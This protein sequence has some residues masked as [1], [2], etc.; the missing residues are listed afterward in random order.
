MHEAGTGSGGAARQFY[1]RHRTTV[2]SVVLSAVGIATGTATAHA[3]LQDSTVLGPATMGCGVVLA[4][5]CCAVQTRHAALAV[6]TAVAPLPG[7]ILAAP[8]SDGPAFGFVPFLAYAFGFAVAAMH[9]EAAV[10]RELDGAEREHPWLPAVTAVGL[11][12]VW[13]MIW[14][15]RTRSADAAVQAIVDVTGTTLSAI[16]LV[17]MGAVL[18]PFDENFVVRIN[19]AHERRRRLCE[20]LAPATVPRWAFSLTG[21]AFVFLALGWF[22]AEPLFGTVGTAASLRLV[23][24]V[25]LLAAAAA[26]IAGGWREA[27]AV[28][29]VAGTAALLTLW[30]MALAWRGIF[31]YPG[32]LEVAT[33][34]VF[35]A[36]C[37]CRQAWAF[38]RF[39]DKPA[40]ARKRALEET[41]SGLMFAS[42]GAIAS[43]VPGLIFLHRDYAIYAGAMLGAAAGGIFFAPAAAA[44]VEVLFPRRRSAEE[45]YGKR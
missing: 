8:V 30:G 14:F 11:M 34:S 37:C 23:L 31:H 33:F 42:A 29:L 40:L 43:M 36:L 38:R 7:L 25:S 12:A 19:R 26:R 18:L 16:V 1:L 4:A 27:V 21:I 15:W 17:P 5:L 6:L 28:I 3:V 24:S 32:A 10:A 45:L 44:A 39:G 41:G 35:L 13:M 9:A 2:M 20:R 22:G